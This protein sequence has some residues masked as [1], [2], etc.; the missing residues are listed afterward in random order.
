MT[1]KIILCDLPIAERLSPR[2]MDALEVFLPK[3]LDSLL[4]YYK[5]AKK[6][7]VDL[8]KLANYLSDVADCRLYEEDGIPYC[9]MYK[10]WIKEL[11]FDSHEKYIRCNWYECFCEQYPELVDDENERIDNFIGY[12]SYMSGISNRKEPYN[13]VANRIQDYFRK[14]T[15]DKDVCFMLSHTSSICFTEKGKYW[16]KHYCTFE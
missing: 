4:P 14:I 11:G 8:L 12:N 2:F 1:E 6:Q 13:C 9:L 3:W 10:P 15:K 16:V 7:N 5:E